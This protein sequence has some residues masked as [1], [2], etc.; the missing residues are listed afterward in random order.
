MDKPYLSDAKK[1]NEEEK[2]VK[3]D[4]FFSVLT[5][6]FKKVFQKKD[7]SYYQDKVVKRVMM[8]TWLCH[9]AYSI[10]KVTNLIMV[11]P[12][13]LTKPL[14]PC[15][16][17]EVAENELERNLVDSE[18]SLDSTDECMDLKYN[19]EIVDAGWSTVRS[20]CIFLT[21]FSLVFDIAIIKWR[22]LVHYC[23]LIELLQIMA[24]MFVPS[25]IITYSFTT[26]LVWH[27][28]LFFALFTA[29][30]TQIIQFVISL[31][32]QTFLV[33]GLVYQKTEIYELKA[34]PALLGIV[35]SF[36]LM[37]SIVVTI[38]YIT[39]LHTL[40]DDSGA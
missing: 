1:S 35:A 29:N 34:L 22:N 15:D 32:F 37:T 27:V 28:V 40:I 30:S 7:A 17:S 36:L 23:A 12:H 26:L 33:L 20:L 3:S 14:P 11:N 6:N 21:I 38:I 19:E 10:Y 13:W 39:E 31:L 8:K 16:I 18:A 4:K 2:S 5:N 9:S 25:D 24:E